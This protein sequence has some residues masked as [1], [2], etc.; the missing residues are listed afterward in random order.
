M[1]YYKGKP[2]RWITCKGN[3]IFIEDGKDVNDVIKNYFKNKGIDSF[4]EDY[5][6]DEE[7]GNVHYMKFK[8]FTY[9]ELTKDEAEK[10]NKSLITEV[11]N[12]EYEQAINDVKN[13]DIDLNNYSPDKYTDYRTL[14]NEILKSINA[15]DVIKR[16]NI[17]S[18]LITNKIKEIKKHKA[19][20]FLSNLPKL[21]EDADIIKGCNP[22]YNKDESYQINCQRCVQTWLLRHMGYDVEA[23]PN[24]KGTEDDSK[25]S[26][27]G[28][29]FAMFNEQPEKIRFPGKRATTQKR[30]IERIVSEAGDGAVYFAVV[31]WYGKSSTHVFVIHNDN[32]KIR[33]IDPQKDK[34]DAE[35]YF[36]K[37]KNYNLHTNDTYI[38]R[39]DNLTLN[40]E[41]MKAICKGRNN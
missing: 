34:K 20:V 12:E 29:H 41:A 40:G 1:Q 4:D 16:S 38:A 21:S 37:T 19:E 18:D 17:V 3:H 27:Q 24:I 31:H 35:Q 2:G 7:Y 28:W 39:V 36:D 5:E 15:P 13:Y 8:G 30:E 32:G 10:I 14:R 26:E 23:L 11:S 22:N 6:D 33:F 9:H 25:L